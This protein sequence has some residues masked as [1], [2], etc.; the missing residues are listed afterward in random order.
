[1]NLKS[2]NKWIEEHIHYSP[3]GPEKISIALGGIPPRGIENKSMCKNSPSFFT[4]ISPKLLFFT[5]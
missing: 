2:H 1:M 3:F 5:S 4:L